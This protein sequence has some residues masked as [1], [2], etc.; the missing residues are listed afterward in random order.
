MKSLTDSHGVED[1]EDIISALKEI[2]IEME[3]S[4]I[5][6]DSK[7]KIQKVLAIA[8]NLEPYI[9][10]DAS[11]N[12][13]GTNAICLALRH[14]APIQLLG[15]EHFNQF[16]RNTNCTAAPIHDPNGKIINVINIGGFIQ[17]PTL[18]T[19]GLVKSIAKIF[20]N[21]IQINHILQELT[22]S[23]CTLNNIIEYNP[24]GVL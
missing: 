1:F 24:S 21:D 15:Q 6:Y 13:I 4:F 7:A 2:S 8:K 14:D 9:P 3:L 10:R 20:E 19:L 18:E 11:E 22:A 5:L 12:V 16:Y 23:N 17:K